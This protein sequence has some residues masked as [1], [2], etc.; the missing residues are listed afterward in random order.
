MS[1]INEIL[2]NAEVALE[3][4]SEAVAWDYFS[5]MRRQGDRLVMWFR[6]GECLRLFNPFAGD[7]H[8]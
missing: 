4:D 6:D 1:Y 3:T 2:V 7:H 5:A 8:V